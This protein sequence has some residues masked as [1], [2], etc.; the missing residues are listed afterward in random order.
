MKDQ[1]RIRANSFY[2]I[3]PF[4]SKLKHWIVNER[5]ATGNQNKNKQHQQRIGNKKQGPVREDSGFAKQANS[6]FFSN[7]SEHH[8][9]RKGKQR[10]K[11]TGD[12]IESFTSPAMISG[13][14]YNSNLK[15]QNSSTPIANNSPFIPSSTSA[16]HATNSDDKVLK[17]KL[18][19]GIV[20]TNNLS[21][22]QN[23]N[24]DQFK[25]K[26]FTETKENV[27]PTIKPFTMEMPECWK[28]FKFDRL[29][30]LSLL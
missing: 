9:S 23:G 14:F 19:K 24:H 7:N 18:P 5:N 21:L 17:N 4:I 29:K 3:L 30:L 27:V 20:K 2:M 6:P 26:L 13:T 28:N 11:S 15:F 22:V 16:F 25:R 12:S 10:N 8:A 1:R